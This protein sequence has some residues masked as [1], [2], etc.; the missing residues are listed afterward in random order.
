MWDYRTKYL[1]T[2]MYDNDYQA[3][4]NHYNRDENNTNYSPILKFR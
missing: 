2:S 3:M 1:T 4:Y